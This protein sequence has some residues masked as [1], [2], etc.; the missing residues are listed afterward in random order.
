MYKDLSEFKWINTNET[1]KLKPDDYTVIINPQ[2]L[3]ISKT[4]HYEY[5][6]CGSFQ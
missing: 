3:D 6:L 4:H 1:K 5:E 2:I